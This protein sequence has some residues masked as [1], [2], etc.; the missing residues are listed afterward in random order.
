MKRTRYRK[1][2]VWLEQYERCACTCVR[3]LKKDLLGYCPR[4]YTNR[5]SVMLVD[6]VFEGEYGYAGQ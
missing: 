4:H 2:M 6:D 5:R 3:L 1:G